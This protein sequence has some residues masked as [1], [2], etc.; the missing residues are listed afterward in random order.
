MSSFLP[1]L[2]FLLTALILVWNIVLAGRI[3]QVRTLPRPFVTLSALAGFLVV[4]ALV[5]E[6]TDCPV[7]A[8]ALAKAGCERALGS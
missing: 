4:P 2:L 8:R 7:D 3:A 6:A 1:L 5:A